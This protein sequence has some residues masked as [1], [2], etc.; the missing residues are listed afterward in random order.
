MISSF[1]TLAQ[2]VSPVNWTFTSKPGSKQ[3]EY[4]IIA[5]AKI[6]EGFHVFSPNPGGDGFL[7]PTSINFAKSTFIKNVGTLTPQRRPITKEMEG[8]GMVNYYEGEVDFNI[9]V[10]TDKHITLHGTVSSQACND[11]MCF[12]PSDVDFT[13]K[14]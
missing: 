2:D 10:E 11:K 14:L 9:T 7:I 6:K 4:I 5:T 13:I 8:I 1:A 12:P 3:N